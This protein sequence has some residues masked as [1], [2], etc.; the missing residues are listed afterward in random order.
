MHGR[1]WITLTSPKAALITA[2]N[3]PGAHLAASAAIAAGAAIGFGIWNWHPAKI[4]LGDVGSV[5]L[6]FVLG[7]LLLSLA[8]SGQWLPALILPLYYLS[9]ATWTLLRRLLRG[10]KF[11][12]AHRCHFY[13]FAVRQS[14]NHGLIALL[15]L[16]CNLVLITAT[17]WAALWDGGWLAL[18]LASVA[19]LLLLYNFATMKAPESSSVKNSDGLDGS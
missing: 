13:Q 5:G 19:V 6:G 9:D 10:E 2:G 1:A 17:V 7:W 14:G 3:G 16:C 18:V 8:A 11:W 4:F 15:V 12:Q